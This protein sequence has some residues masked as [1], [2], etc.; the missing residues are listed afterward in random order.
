M[1]QSQESTPGMIR[2]EV[3]AVMAQTKRGGCLAGIGVR[4]RLGDLGTIDPKYD[5]AIR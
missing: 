5:I 3:A 4:G 1:M 2:P